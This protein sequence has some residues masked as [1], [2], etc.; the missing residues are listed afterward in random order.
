MKLGISS[1]KTRVASRI[2]ILFIICSMLPVSVF[3]VISFIHVRSQL[4]DQCYAT[5][6]RESKS[7]AVSIYER[8]DFL[9]SELSFIAANYPDS[10]DSLNLDQIQ[11]VNKRIGE[12]FQALALFR[13]KKLIN[14]HGEIKQPLQISSEEWDHLRS[15]KILLTRVDTTENSHNLYMCIALKPDSSG[16]NILIGRLNQ[17]YILDV[18]DRK[19]PLTE[20]YITDRSNSFL[21]SSV[22]DISSSP[23]RIVKEMKRSPSGQFEW[24]YQDGDYIASYSSLFLKPNFYYHEWIIVLFELKSDVIAP[25]NNFILFFAFIIVFT[26]GLVFFLSVNLIKKNTRPIA[27]LKDATR[28]ISEGFFGHRVTVESGDEFESLANDFNEMSTKLKEDQDLLINAAKM[29]TMGQM[30]AGIMHEIKQPLSAIYGNVELA[31][32]DIL[33]ADER[34]DRL[35]R[36][37]GAVDRLSSI[38]EKFRSFSSPSK[39]VVEDVSLNKTV[40]EIYNLMEHEF[41]LRGVECIMEMENNLPPVHG[42]D[43]ELQQVVS[44]L[45]VNA[46]HALEDKDG[47]H[48]RILIRTNSSEAKVYLSIDDNGCG[49]PKELHERIF[50]PFFTTKTS[51]KGTGLGMAI[52]QS[53]LHRHGASINFESEEGKGT[54]F[55]VTFPR[56]ESKQEVS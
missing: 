53:I 39:D 42:D 2:F 13:D 3:A 28:K 45:V 50:D 21:F 14:I 56:S 25:M 31:L 8:L 9:R 23:D 6:Q 4:I 48:R 15:G 38:L 16:Q 34:R 22:P 44:N 7:L 12:H 32:L 30:A 46:M 5:L 18:A 11:L 33:D 20:L 40:S 51:D 37:L 43:Q 55:T 10:P 35:K 19:P 36:V 17:E 41:H 47:D 1:F 52:I 24:Q 26:F 54:K 29:S 27:V 49:I